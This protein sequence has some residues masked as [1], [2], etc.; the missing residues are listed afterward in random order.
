MFVFQ[1]SSQA[2]RPEIAVSRRKGALN[3]VVGWISSLRGKALS[4]TKKLLS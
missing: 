3:A 2:K 1:A 4:F